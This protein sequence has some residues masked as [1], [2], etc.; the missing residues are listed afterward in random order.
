MNYMKTLSIGLAVVVLGLIV[1]P[2]FLNVEMSYLI[3]FLFMAFIYVVIAQGWN[4]VGGYAG[5][6]SLGQHAFFGLGA[7]TT[8][9]FWVH[10]LVGTG[11]GY[12]FNPLLMILSGIVPAIVAIIV[13][14][15]LL[16][17]LKGDYFALGSLGLGELMRVFFIKGGDITGAQDGLH[18]PSGAYDSMLPYYY[19]GLLLAVAATAGVY[20]IMRSRIGM[21][22]RAINEDD[23][24]ASSHGINILYYKILAFAMG[25]FFTGVAGSL[26]GIYIFHVN[27][28]SV[29]NI[30]Y[31]LYPILMCVLGG[32]ATIF[33]PVI[34]SFFMAAVFVI[35]EQHFPMI[36]PI[37]SGALIVLVMRF[38]P[39]GIIGLKSR[40]QREQ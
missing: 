4:V 29:L 19:V 7:Y 27:P 3:Y 23:I 24:S 26:Y 33:G 9:M 16:S 21:A 5:Q 10:D 14:I 1:L 31:G 30:N 39:T 35:A 40:L 6:I 20:F 15:P 18:L 36:H 22:F 12:Y 11:T 32:G 37:V 8:A 2:F 17:R 34:G 38:M 13:G 28:D 25:A